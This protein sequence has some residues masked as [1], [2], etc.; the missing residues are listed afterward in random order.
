[1][2]NFTSI[3]AGIFVIALFG[4]M[5]TASAHY[6]AVDDPI[7]TPGRAGY[8]ITDFGTVDCFADGWDTDGGNLGGDDDG[9]SICNEWEPANA[10]LQIEF[11]PTTGIR[12]GSVFSY[13][14]PCGAG[15]S[16]P[17]C[18]SPDKK[19]VYLEL[20]W[21]MDSTN[22]SHK[23]GG[24]VVQSVKNAFDAA[25][26]GGITLHVINGEYPLSSTYTRQGDI[27]WHKNSLYTNW[28]SQAGDLWQGFYRLKQYT[29]GTVSERFANTVVPAETDP[30]TTN[31]TYA[32][33][34]VRLPLTAKFQ[35]FHYG[36]IINTRAEQSSSSG[37]AEIFGNDLVWS[38]GDFSPKMGNQ[39]QQKAVFMHEL[40]HNFLLDHGGVNGGTADSIPNK[41]NYFS[42]MN[43]PI[44]FVYPDGKDLCRPLDYSNKNMATL[45]ENNLVEGN[46]VKDTLGA[47][48]NYPASPSCFKS[49][50]SQTGASMPSSPSVDVAGQGRFFWYSYPGS[51]GTS[52]FDQS[53]QG[54][55]VNW[56]F[57]QP[58]D[59]ADIINGQ[60]IN[61]NGGNI[62]PLVSNSDWDSL[63]FDFRS[64]AFSRPPVTEDDP[65]PLK[66][67]CGEEGPEEPII[68][69]SFTSGCREITS[70]DVLENRIEA[71]DEVIEANESDSSLVDSLNLIKTYVQK[72]DLRNVIEELTKLKKSV[73]GNEIPTR[74]K[75]KAKGSLYN[76]L[77]GFGNAYVTGTKVK[78]AECK[79]GFKQIVSFRDGNFACV[80][81]RTV[82]ELEKAGWG[83][84]L[85]RNKN[86]LK[87]NSNALKPKDNG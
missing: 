11:K 87:E 40:G 24:G 14:L 39:A 37:W 82:V 79:P 46:G 52:A 56:D 21:M 19:D 47:A 78:S 55:G 63:R 22:N 25:P 83:F 48:Y 57:T 74:D 69:D 51:T 4:L 35:V 54:T 71:I 80:K 18:P 45:S 41:P 9:D 3:L 75:E 67:Y 70:E 66:E 31:P 30:W 8:V 23:P 50:G 68:M 81:P 84:E 17:V 29:F 64:S 7:P 77:E 10:G 59:D 26:N 49:W 65:D 5:N 12:A 6:A 58:V 15:T 44:Q 2:K 86:D 43:P 73:I 61:D 36:L 34:A 38:L 62:Q 28:S 60:D 13:T 53:G 27:K 76:L 20:D 72:D 33:D 42:V 1:M 85:E 16:D 32:S